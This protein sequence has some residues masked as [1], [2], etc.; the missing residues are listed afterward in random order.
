M[1]QNKDIDGVLISTPDHWHALIGIDVAEAGKDAYLQKPASLT[2]TEGRALSN[3]VH[4]TGR[5]FQDGRQQR[6]SQQFHY[7]DELFPN[8]LIGKLKTVYVGLPADGT[9]DE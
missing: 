9:G 6:S 8:G 4:R 2:I 3:A 7:A 1:L 5:I